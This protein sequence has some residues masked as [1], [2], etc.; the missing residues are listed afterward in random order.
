VDF[1]VE[2][3]RVGVDTT[4][5]VCL[6]EMLLAKKLKCGHLFHLN[7]L[8]TWI[9]HNVVCPACRAEIVLDPLDETTE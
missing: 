3:N 1:Q 9:E 2:E 7:C 4:C 5:I 8:R 6:E